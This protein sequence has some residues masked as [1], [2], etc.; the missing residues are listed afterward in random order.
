[1]KES[2]VMLRGIGHFIS[3][4]FPIEDI[5][6]AINNESVASALSQDRDGAKGIDRGEG[7]VDERTRFT[8]LVVF[9]FCIILQRI[10]E[11]PWSAGRRCRR[12]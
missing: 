6:N 2:V 3:N 7:E 8:V 9:S 5:E 12:G 11:V 10:R 1:M 4:S